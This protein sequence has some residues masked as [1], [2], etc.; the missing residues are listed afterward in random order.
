MEKTCLNFRKLLETD[1]LP[2]VGAFNGL[3][4]KAIKRKGI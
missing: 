3:V 1:C 2:I 4:A